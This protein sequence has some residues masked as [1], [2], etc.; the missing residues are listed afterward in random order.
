MIGFRGGYWAGTIGVV[1]GERENDVEQ[2]DGKRGSVAEWQPF[3]SPFEKGGLGGISKDQTVITIWRDGNP[4]CCRGQPGSPRS[5]W[6][7]AP[8]RVWCPIRRPAQLKGR[9]YFY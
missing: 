8:P 7:N 2:A 3:G 1:T 6:R 5:G 4:G 9:L